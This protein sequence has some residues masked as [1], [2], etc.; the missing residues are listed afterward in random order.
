MKRMTLWYPRLN[1]SSFPLPG[2]CSV[3][4]SLSILVKGAQGKPGK[5]SFN[6]QTSCYTQVQS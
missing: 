1:F 4:S 5:K 2:L 6:L 3:E